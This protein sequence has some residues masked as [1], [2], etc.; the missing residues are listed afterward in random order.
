MSDVKLS[1]DADTLICL[2][3][4]YYL[5]LCG[6]GIPKSKAKFLGSS[7]EI[8]ENIIPEWNFDD[9]DSTCNELG[10]NQLLDI[11]PYNNICGIVNLSDNGIVYMENRFSDKIEK[12]VDYISKFIP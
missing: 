2:I 11:S 9:V 12:V 1:K 4:K 7:H 10:K 3:Y 5:E 6:T 8:H